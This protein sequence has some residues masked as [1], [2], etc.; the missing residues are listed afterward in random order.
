TLLMSGSNTVRDNL[1]TEQLWQVT[2]AS[3]YGG[4]SP[5]LFDVQKLYLP[6]GSESHNSVL[7]PAVRHPA[8]GLRAEA[9]AIYALP[10][11]ER[12]ELELGQQY[13]APRHKIDFRGIRQTETNYSF[14]KLD[15]A[16]GLFGKYCF[17]YI[18][19]LRM[20]YVVGVYYHFN[21]DFLKWQVLLINA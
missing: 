12:P 21:I 19:C 13:F 6:A 3:V 7:Y 8:E 1:T 4:S 20:V 18:L 17:V 15:C 11:E 2:N 14:C 16:L 5:A 9:E 10:E